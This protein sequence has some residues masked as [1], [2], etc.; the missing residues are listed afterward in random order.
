MRERLGI[1]ISG[2]GTTM[3]EIIKAS[4]AGE[5][6]IDVAC[7]IASTPAAG[8]IQKARRLGISEKDVVVV[9]LDEYRNS[10]HRVDQEHF[11]SVLLN[12]LKSRDV[13]I[14][15][16]N[17]WLAITPPAV[18][19]EYNGALF[20]Q[21]PGPQKETGRLYGLQPHAVML[22]LAEKTKRN[23]GTEVIVHHVTERLDEGKVVGRIKIPEFLPGETT[24]TL[25][26]RV[27]PLEHQLQITL[28]KQVV[29][30][31]VH[32]VSDEQTYI[33]TGEESLLVEARKYARRMYPQG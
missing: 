4:R 27:L 17:G 3:E 22:Y 1:L 13:T 25:Y 23:H 6:P 18:V 29:Q 26:R 8:G 30:G 7:V 24:D 31:D 20:N 14:V 10:D 15:T 11:G 32:E 12:E 28:L 16:Q 33:R 2:N 19:R 5:I 21:H 9:N